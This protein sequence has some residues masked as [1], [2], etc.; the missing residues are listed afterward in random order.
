MLIS[1]TAGALSTVFVIVGMFFVL[2]GFLKDHNSPKYIS[3]QFICIPNF[4]G[5][6]QYIIGAVLVLLG[7][8]IYLGAW[9]SSF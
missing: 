9:L 2:W 6:W 3:G 4:P 1:I 7:L 8:A 5:F